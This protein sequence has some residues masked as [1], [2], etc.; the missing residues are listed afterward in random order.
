MN[1]K[2]QI[3]SLLNKLG[4]SADAATVL[5]LLITAAAGCCAYKGYFY[6]GGGLL[7]LAGGLDLMDGAIARLTGKAGKFGGILDS[8]L[9]RYGDFFI[10]A[11]ILGFFLRVAEPGIYVL[12]TLSAMAGSF[13]ISYIRARAECVIDK[14]KVG[15]WERGERLVYLALGMLTHNVAWVI[16][17]LSIG[18]HMTAFYRLYYAA[19]ATAD[20]RPDT[21]PA[22]T[23]RNLI[24]HPGGR[25][26]TLYWVKCIV[27]FGA[28]FC[29]IPLP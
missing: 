2:N 8:S 5:G 22:V 23:L 13:E 20:R 25:M 9:D 29:P 6:W 19:R 21:S 14:C 11:G 15:F 3:A 24:F 17:V 27:L 10:L 26:N 7:L 4:L 18:T 1:L 16:V 28:L 12:L